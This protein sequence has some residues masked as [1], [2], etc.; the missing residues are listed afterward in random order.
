MIIHAQ[1]I[2]FMRRLLCLGRVGFARVNFHNIA[3]FEGDLV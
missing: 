2:I 1:F 3:N